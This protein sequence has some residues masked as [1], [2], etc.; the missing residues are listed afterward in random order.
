PPPVGMSRMAAIARIAPVL[1]EIGRRARAQG[2]SVGV[3]PH[4]NTVVETPEETDAIMARC[5]PALVGLALD[6][7]HF[8][9]AGGDVVGAIKKHGARLNYLHFKDGVR[10][11]TRPDF[12]PNLRDLGKGEVDF[13]GVMR[14]L[15]T[16]AYQGWINVEQD[17][18]ATSPGESCRAS[19]DYVHRV[20]RPIYA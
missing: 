17:F 2:V 18:T 15:K 3:H 10:P 7:G 19:M 16:L 6:T 1:E 4:L 5:D 13:P 8:H 9:L 12:F 14:A 20:L 11:F